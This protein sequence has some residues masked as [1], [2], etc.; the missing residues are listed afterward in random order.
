MTPEGE[1]SDDNPI[2]NSLVY[3]LRHR[4]PQDLPETS[5]G[6]SILR[7]SDST[8]GTNTMSSKPEASTVGHRP[9][10]PAEATTPRPETSSIPFTSGASMWPAPAEWPSPVGRSGWPASAE[11]FSSRSP[12]TTSANRPGIWSA[13]RYRPRPGGSLWILRNNMDGRV[14]PG[15]SNNRILRIPPEQ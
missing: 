14:D 3:S 5:P 2:P 13:A 1:V 12:W 7:S 6:S 9:K 15:E 10:R 4:N 11:N 8:H